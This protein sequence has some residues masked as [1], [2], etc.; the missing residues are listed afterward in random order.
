MVRRLVAGGYEVQVVDRSHAV[1]EQLAADGATPVASIAAVA[2]GADAVI[3]CVYSDEQV[4][5]VALAEGLL[6]SMEPG[7][8]LVIHTTGSPRTAQELATYGTRSG[9]SVVDATISGGPDQIAVGQITVFAGGDRGAVDRVRPIVGQYAEPLLYVGDT[10]A[11]QAIKLLNNALFAANIALVMETVR[12]AVRLGLT[13]QEALQSLRHGSS[14]SQA[15]GMI[16]ASGSTA[17]FA[18]TVREFLNKDVEVV[19]RVVSGLGVDLG[20]LQGVLDS[21]AGI[22]ILGTPVK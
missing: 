11:G 9:V 20:A 5:D 15:L 7:S 10:G 2:T 19:R 6:D 1:L 14:D 21:P 18:D 22:S 13:E 16:A 8:V 17:L 12:L 3:L 4:R